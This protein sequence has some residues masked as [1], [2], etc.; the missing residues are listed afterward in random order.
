MTETVIDGVTGFRCRTLGE[1]QTGVRR[2][3]ELDPNVI[4]KSAVDRYS[5]PVIGDK[6][7]TYFN[8]L[9]T[10]WVKA[11]M[12]GQHELGL[13]RLRNDS[14]E[15]SGAAAHGHRISCKSCRAR[16]TMQKT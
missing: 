12:R 1:F 3:S 7:E 5:L 4:R 15:P 10:L 2:C 8:R 6:Y 16:S 11:G 14:C 9:L 13:C